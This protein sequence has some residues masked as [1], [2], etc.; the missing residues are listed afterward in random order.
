M[1]PFIVRGT[2]LVTPYML[3]TYEIEDIRIVIAKDASEAYTKYQ[4]YWT[5]KNEEYSIYYGPDGQVMETVL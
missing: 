5:S 3:D 2:V 4:D 1:I